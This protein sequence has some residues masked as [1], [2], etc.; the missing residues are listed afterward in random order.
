[1]VKP[2]DL[3]GHLASPPK[4]L[5]GGLESAPEEATIRGTEENKESKE[6]T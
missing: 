5:V 1:M 2:T 6:S 3:P 4:A